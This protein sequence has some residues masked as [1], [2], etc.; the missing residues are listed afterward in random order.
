MSTAFA[1]RAAVESVVSVGGSVWVSITTRSVISEPRGG[2]R[3][4]RVLSRSKPP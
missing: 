2:M 3:E 4:G 1:I